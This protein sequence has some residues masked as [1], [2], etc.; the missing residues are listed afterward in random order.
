MMKADGALDAR[1]VTDWEYQ[2]AGPFMVQVMR[3]PATLIH[4][5]VVED[6]ADALRFAIDEFADPP[7]AYCCLAVV[8]VSGAMI[9][10]YDFPGSNPNWFGV[11]ASYRLIESSG[12]VDLFRCG[13]WEAMAHLVCEAD[14]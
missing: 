6:L 14:R 2:P 13:S 3:R 12:W 4:R 11:A 5:E 9:F 10:G 7:R 1:I 8:D